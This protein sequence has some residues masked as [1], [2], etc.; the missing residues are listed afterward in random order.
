MARIPGIR[1]RSRTFLLLTCAATAALA[2]AAPAFAGDTQ[3]SRE[4]LAQV[5]PGMAGSAQEVPQVASRPVPEASAQRGLRGLTASAT[6]LDTLYDNTYAVDLQQMVAFTTDD[7]Q[8]VAG[9]TLDTNTLIDGD[10]VTTFVNTDGNPGTGEPVFGGAD[11]AVMIIG[12]TTGPDYVLTYRWNGSSFQ[13][14]FFPSLISFPSG[15]TDEVWAISAAELGVAPGT[16][17]TLVFASLYQGLYDD[18]FDFAPEPGIA[19]FAFTAGSLSPAPPVLAAAPVAVV[20]TSSVTGLRPSP[21]LGVRSFVLRTTPNAIKMRLGWVEGQGRVD[22][23]L[24]LRARINGLPQTRYASG[25]GR[26]GSR[27]SNRTIRVPA[28]WKGTTISARLRVQDA[29]RLLTRTRTLRF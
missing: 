28:S 29:A 14:A 5:A 15:T 24:T 16:R 20:P 18:Y 2:S 27:T 13:D 3:S 26:A 21:P 4:V 11:V 9:I 17:T 12:Y 10:S 8:Y 7:G 22:W 25:S 19:P 23:D 6:F 1:R